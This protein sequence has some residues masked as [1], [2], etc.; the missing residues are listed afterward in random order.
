MNI[1]VTMFT[2]SRVQKQRNYRL[3]FVFFCFFLYLGYEENWS[4]STKTKTFGVLVEH[5]AE[6]LDGHVFYVGDIMAW[7]LKL[8]VMEDIVHQ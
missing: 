7:D 2:V 3:V 1:G 8:K 6:G 5:T 4:N